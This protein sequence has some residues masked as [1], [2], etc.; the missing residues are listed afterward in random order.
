MDIAIDQACLQNLPSK[1]SKEHRGPSIQQTHNCTRASFG[2]F[3]MLPRMV[4]IRCFALSMWVLSLLARTLP[5]SACVDSL[6]LRA[7]ARLHVLGDGRLHMIRPGLREAIYEDFLGWPPTNRWIPILGLANSQWLKD[8]SAKKASISCRKSRWM[9]HKAGTK[10]PCQRY[11][12]HEDGGNSTTSPLPKCDLRNCAWIARSSRAMQTFSVQNNDAGRH[13]RGRPLLT[14]PFS[15]T[16]RTFSSE[17]VRAMRL[18][19]IPQPWE[20]GTGDRPQKC[21]RCDFCGLRNVRHTAKSYFVTKLCITLM[22]VNWLEEKS[23]SILRTQR[24]LTVLSTIPI[25]NYYFKTIECSLQLQ[26]EYFIN[27]FVSCLYLLY[28]QQR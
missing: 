19:G 12:P 7:S 16:L 15:K 8:L 27:G 1:P 14:R 2:I 28:G 26:G 18:K 3:R 9:L 21:G 13:C 20:R 23:C 24:I 17:P 5:V 25:T 4:R 6:R 10:V 22:Y 11:L